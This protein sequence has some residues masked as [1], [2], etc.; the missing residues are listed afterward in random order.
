MDSR[1]FLKVKEKKKK[2]LR[3]KMKSWPREACITVTQ[4]VGNNSPN[5]QPVGLAAPLLALIARAPFNPQWPPCDPHS[6]HLILY[7][8]RW[9][10]REVKFLTQGYTARTGFEL[11]THVFTLTLPC[12]EYGVRV[13]ELVKIIKY[14]K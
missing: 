10:P 3:R 11:K 7:L 13:P 6:C 4:K 14:L 12:M 8:R 2:S 1:E 5:Q 9:R